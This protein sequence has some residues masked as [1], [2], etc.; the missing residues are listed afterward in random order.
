MIIYKSLFFLIS[1]LLVIMPI[2][3]GGTIDPLKPDDN[4]IQYGQ[5]KKFDSV[6][7]LIGKYG[8]VTFNASAVAID[9]RVALTAAHVVQK[10]SD[11]YLV[12][13]N[14]K[15]KISKVLCHKDFN[16]HIFGVG[17]IAI[18]Y[19]DEDIGLIDFPFLYDNRDEIG[20][21]CSIS[22]YGITGTFATGAKISDGTKRAGLNNI[23][24]IDNEL[25]VV[26]P[27][28]STDKNYTVLEFM[29]SH[30]DSGGGLF[31]DKKLAGINSSVM[32][33][34]KK[35]DS[36]YTDEGCHTRISTYA[37]WIQENI[38]YEK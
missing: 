27:S 15:I 8:D 3:Y 2:M 19:C 13:D 10:A 16:E 22:G 5:L 20:K 21:E 29:I 14:K 33:A 7:K 28:R 30:G 6:V 24:Y 11:C 12:V 31:I 9:K 17:D 38:N 23:E 32:A 1:F 37:P 36:S 26:T 25:L 4:Y 35:T 34:D 18:C